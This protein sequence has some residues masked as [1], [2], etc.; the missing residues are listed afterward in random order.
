[1]DF[2]K[3]T[4]ALPGYLPSWTVPRGVEQLLSAYR[5][6]GLEQADLEGDR[7]LRIK[8]ISGLLESGRLD[9]DLRWVDAAA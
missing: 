1:V 5:E 8:H 6:I 9:S 3:I 4:D 7:Y 2:S